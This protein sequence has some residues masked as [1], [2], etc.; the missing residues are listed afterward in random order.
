MR[1]KEQLQIAIIFD[2]QF[3]KRLIID[4]SKSV[5]S[6]K[7]EKPVVIHQAMRGRE[8]SHRAEAILKAVVRAI[9]AKTLMEALRQMKVAATDKT[10]G[11]LSTKLAQ[12]L[13]IIE[14]DYI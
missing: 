11:T 7:E 6:I 12:I 13:A 5:H 8:V 10:L 1:L 14:Y 3:P 4:P 2:S 9:I